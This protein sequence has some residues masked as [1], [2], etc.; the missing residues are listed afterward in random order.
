MML[1]EA[2]WCGGVGQMCYG[3]RVLAAGIAMMVL[4]SQVLEKTRR[5]SDIMLE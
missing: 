2:F 4:Y 5:S 1:K 3:L